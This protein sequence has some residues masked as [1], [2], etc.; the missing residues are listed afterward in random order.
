M[1]Q[2]TL[3]G[4]DLNSI[5]ELLGH[6][7]NDITYSTGWILSKCE[8]LLQSL[9]YKITGKKIEIK[10]CIIRLQEFKEKDKGYTDIEIYIEGELFIIIE[11]KKG[12]NLPEIEQLERYISRFFNYSSIDHKLVVISECKKSYAKK[13]LSNYKLDIPVE[14]ISWQT[15]LNLSKDVYSK[16][17]YYEK[18]LLKEYRT[19]LRGV[20]S[21]RDIKSN[22]VFCVS[23]G[24]DTPSWSTLS[25]IDIVEKKNKYFYLMGPNWPKEPPNYVAF[26]YNGKLQAIRH[27]ESYQIVK[28]LHDAIPEIEPD[29]EEGLHFILDLGPPFKPNR[30]VRNGKIWPNGLYW[31]MLDTLFTCNTIKEAKELTQ[32]RFGEV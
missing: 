27:V 13:M 9:C 31:C 4:N 24:H 22:M 15:I 11:A 30:E 28:L 2:V 19:Y 14:F 3:H 32:K 29:F 16:V 26:R 25:W 10:D 21:M 6:N 5:F 1:T 23:L 7:E 20:I 8:K 17:G 12:W 18:S